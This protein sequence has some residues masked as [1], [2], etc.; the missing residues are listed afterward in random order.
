MWELLFFNY[1]ANV[2]NACSSADMAH[3]ATYQ[4]AASYFGIIAVTLIGGL[5]IQYLGLLSTAFI[6]SASYLLYLLGTAFAARPA[7]H[8]QRVR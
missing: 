6:L 3:V 4:Y 1:E 8:L 5:L 7:T 2:V